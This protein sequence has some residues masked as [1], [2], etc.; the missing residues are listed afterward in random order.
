MQRFLLSLLSLVPMLAAAFTLTVKPGELASSRPSLTPHMTVEVTGQVDAADLAYLADSV[1]SGATL[2]LSGVRTEVLPP[3]ILAGLRASRLLL[4]AG[5]TSIGEGALLGAEI[6]DVEIP[7][8]VTSLGNHSFAACRKLIGVTFASGNTLTSIPSRT[9]DGCVLLE[10]IDLPASVETI[11]TRAFAGCN[12]LSEFKFTSRLERVGEE[13]FAASGITGVDLSACRSLRAIGAR[14]WA[15]CTALTSVSLPSVAV[16]D[17]DAIFMGCQSLAEVTL[18]QAASSLPSLTLAGASSLGT[19]T[20]P[21]TLA[22]IGESAFEGCTSLSE[23]N[24]R[25]IEGNVPSLGDRVWGGVNQPQVILRVAQPLEQDYLNALQWRDFS[26]TTSSLREL[27]ADAVACSDSSVR[28]SAAFTDRM[29][30]VSSD[31]PL[32]AV[33]VY[34]LDGTTLTVRPPSSGENRLV[35]MDTSRLSGTVFVVSVV[36]A[37]SDTPVIFKLLRR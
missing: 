17:G 10:V 36:A 14:A 11:E 21:G 13:A 34:A 1:P 22:H 20:L 18:P 27:P 4:P 19:V 15:E 28:V 32:T 25:A 31:S 12:S 37:A 16:L 33:S 9:F 23:V 7:A 26:I 6:T 35:R 3:Y 5:L 2:D 29:L 24:A 30:T 8:G